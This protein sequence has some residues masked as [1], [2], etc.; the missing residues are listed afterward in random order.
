MSSVSRDPSPEI[1]LL[2]STSR[3]PPSVI[4]LRSSIHMRLRSISGRDLSPDGIHLLL[5]ISGRNPS[6]ATIHHPPRSIWL[7]PFVSTMCIIALLWAAFRDFSCSSV[8]SLKVIV[9]DL[10]NVRLPLTLHR[11]PIIHPVINCPSEENTY[12]SIRPY[13][14]GSLSPNPNPRSGLLS[15]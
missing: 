3:H 5:S 9:T 14:M 7:Q 4:H 13:G 11:S 15:T 12:S 6:L 8:S 2:S 10:H 1:H